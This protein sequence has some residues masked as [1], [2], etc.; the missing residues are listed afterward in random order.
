[1]GSLLGANQPLNLLPAVVAPS[2]LTLVS[3]NGTSLCKAMLEILAYFK[4]SYFLGIVVFQ[5]PSFPT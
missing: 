1:M 2:P 3:V 5:L 4:C